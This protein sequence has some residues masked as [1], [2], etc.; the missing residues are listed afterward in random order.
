MDVTSIPMPFPSLRQPPPPGV[1][2]KTKT[3][4]LASLN[5]GLMRRL[6]E[7]HLPSEHSLSMRLDR[8]QRLPMAGTAAV[9]ALREELGMSAAA[10]ARFGKGERKT[11]PTDEANYRLSARA[12]AL[13]SQAPRARALAWR[14]ASINAG[15]GRSLAAALG[16]WRTQV[17]KQRMAMG[18]QAKLDEASAATERSRAAS[19]S[20]FAEVEQLQKQVAELQRQLAESQASA[21]ADPP[22]TNSSLSCSSPAAQETLSAARARAFKGGL[23]WAHGVERVQLRAVLAAWKCSV[24]AHN[25]LGLLKARM[26]EEEAHRAAALRAQ[27]FD[28]DTR[29]SELEARYRI[30][31]QGLRDSLSEAQ[32]DF[33]S[34]LREA[35]PDPDEHETDD[36]QTESGGNERTPGARESEDAVAELEELRSRAAARLGALESRRL[37]AAARLSLAE[38]RQQDEEEDIPTLWPSIRRAVQEAH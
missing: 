25:S 6:E 15:K 37:Q 12:D 29:Y 18:V 24:E 9:Q 10:V 19:V 2:R 17:S 7:L 28:C 14:L 33:N 35:L 1:R 38:G 23:A 16:A 34:A 11:N 27:K 32:G 36:L 26:F 31:L 8:V 3:I 20:A 13:W 4:R 30:A 21:A 5:P 22:I